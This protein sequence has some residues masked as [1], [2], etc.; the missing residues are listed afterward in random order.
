MNSEDKPEIWRPIPSFE[1]YEASSLGRIRWRHRVRKVSPDQKG[2]LRVSFWTEKGSRKFSVHVLVAAAFHG[3][4]PDGSVTRHVNGDNSDNRPE[5][6]V[7]GT[8]IE[9]EADKAAH[10]TKII[11]INHPANKFTEAQVIEARRLYTERGK[12]FSCGETARSMGVSYKTIKYIVE[13]KRW[14]HLA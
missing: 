10:G 13:R 5:N 1:S 12:S 9:N 6:L 7:Y 2:Y 8:S 11:G 3:E 4:R 14:K